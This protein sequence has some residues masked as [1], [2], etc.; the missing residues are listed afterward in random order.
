[1][2]LET[3]KMELLLSLLG[4]VAAFFAAAT[5]YY[6][7]RKEKLGRLVAEAELST[8]RSSLDFATLL[9]EWSLFENE[10]RDLLETTEIDRFIIFRAW[11]GYLSPKWTTSLYQQRTADQK[12]QS[13]I[14]FEIDQDYVNRLKEVNSHRIKKWKTNELSEGVLKEVYEAEGVKSTLWAHIYTKEPSDKV[15]A[16]TYC[17]FSSHKTDTISKTTENKCKIIAN[18]LTGMVLL[19]E[20]NNNAK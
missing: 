12:I 6:R 17:S 4:L 20:K 11:N 3:I 8:G 15:K 13:Y 14:H 2:A 5:A 1:M 16:M 9:E 18:M 10:L 7:Y 19:A